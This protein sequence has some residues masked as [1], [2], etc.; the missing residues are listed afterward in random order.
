MN[1]RNDTSFPPTVSKN[2]KCEGASACN[3]RGRPRINDKNEL[4]STIIEVAL[5]IF[6]DHHYAGTTMDLVASHCGISKRTLYGYFPS[7][8]SLFQEMIVTHRSAIIALPGNYDHLSL[9]EALME[10]CRFNQTD[11]EFARQNAILRVFFMETPA[12]QELDEILTEHGGLNTHT[13]LSNW[14]EDQVVKG[15]IET[16]DVSATAKIL[17]DMMIAIRVAKPLTCSEVPEVLSNDASY[18]KALVRVIA[19]GL[20]PR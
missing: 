5:K 20:S 9:E 16:D 8:T 12:T 2:A 7:K 13:L 1:D 18:R 11:E 14:I 19:R 10:V 4:K 3:R 17:I 6:V 15:R